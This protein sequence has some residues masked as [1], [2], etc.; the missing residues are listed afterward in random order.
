MKLRQIRNL[1]IGAAALLSPVALFGQ[2]IP[3]E[4]AASQTQANPTNQQPPSTNQQPPSTAMQD[5]GTNANEVSQTM[6][7]KMFLRHAAEGG[8]AEVKLGQLAAEKAGS[9]EVRAFGRKMVDEHTTLNSQIASVADS[10]GVRLPKTITKEDQAEYNKLSALSGNDFDTEYLTVM[11]KDHRKDLRDFRDE[12]AAATD[13][14]LKTTVESGEKVI[15]DHL[16]TVDKLARDKGVPVPPHGGNKP[17]A[18]PT[19]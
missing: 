5:S 7:D 10:M 18:A 19:S 3:I 9:E 2:A 8:L 13:P 6:K 12:A 15:R 14:T 17:P 16:I 11:V 4:I 1:A